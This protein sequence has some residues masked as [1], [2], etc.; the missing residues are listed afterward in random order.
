MLAPTATQQAANCPNLAPV[1][2]AF[3]FASMHGVDQ[4]LAR[5]SMLPDDLLALLRAGRGV[6]LNNAERH[7]ENRAY[8]LVFSRQDNAFFIVVVGIEPGTAVAAI[9]TVLTQYMYEND[10]G[11]FYPHILR[12]ALRNAVPDK[13]MQRAYLEQHPEIQ[14]R[15]ALRAAEAWQQKCTM[16][17]KAVVITI[18]YRTLSGVVDRAKLQ[19][20]PVGEPTNLADLAET[21]ILWSWLADQ[22]QKTAIHPD[23]VLAVKAHRGNE[24]ARLF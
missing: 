4:L 13:A 1:M 6:W 5:T 12:R 2:P 9:I 18:D 22:L 20:A 7:Y 23:A 8:I 15:H 14:T 21:S 3:F 16:R 19:G 17:E 10:R 24:I 11:A